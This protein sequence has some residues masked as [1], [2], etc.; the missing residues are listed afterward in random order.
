MP[1]G[2]IP[3]NQCENHVRYG[4]TTKKDFMR[5]EMKAIRTILVLIVFGG[6]TPALLHTQNGND[7]LLFVS[8]TPLRVSVKIDDEI[9]GLSPLLMKQISPGSHRIQTYKPGLK[10]KSLEVEIESHEVLGVHF[11]LERDVPGQIVSSK[12]GIVYGQGE[13]TKADGDFLIPYGTY[14]LEVEEERITIEP[15]FPQESTLRVL[16]ISLPALVAL[17]ALLTLTDSVYPKRSGLFFSP[18]T[19]TAYSATLGV[20][21]YKIVLDARKSRYLKSVSTVPSQ[22]EQKTR[23]SEVW[24]QVAQE[25]LTRDELDK[26]LEYYIAVVEQDRDSLLY[27]HAFYKI[28]KIHVIKGEFEMAKDIFKLIVERYP[29][30]DLYD[31]SLRSLAEVYFKQERYADSLAALDRM[32]FADPLYSREEIEQIKRELIERQEGK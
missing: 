29:L 18:V 10:S 8:S 23:D 15:S 26:A 27:P 13:R 19:L 2:T 17:S 9:V 1:E 22:V 30:I 31:K 28:A 5:A 25:L 3:D 11:D 7:A 21:G 6:L 32:V 24:F 4:E 16:N 12:T 20:L 14:G